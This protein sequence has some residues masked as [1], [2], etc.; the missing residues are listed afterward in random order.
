MTTKILIDNCVKHHA[1]ALRGGWQSGGIQY[2]G[3]EVPI[4]TGRICSELVSTQMNIGPQEGAIAALAQQFL[5]N[6]IE[7]YTTDALGLET[8]HQPSGRFSGTNYGDFSLLFGVEF[9]KIITLSNFSFSMPQDNV[10]EKFRE[11]L[12]QSNEQT[13]LK[14][15]NALPDKSRQDAWHLYCIQRFGLDVFLTTDTKLI[16]Q[17]SSIANTQLKTE[18][19]QIV[20]TPKELCDDLN[21][22]CLD[23]IEIINFARDKLGIDSFWL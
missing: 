4:E 3:G 6:K 10:I 8:F 14:I 2:W 12:N 9:Q 23:E 16:G 15:K 5:D 1:V 17:V 20:R 13:F 21:I 22:C 18:I 7:A 19:E 11:H